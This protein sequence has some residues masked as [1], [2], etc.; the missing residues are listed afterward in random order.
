[1]N[2]K[3]K[4]VYNKSGEKVA[5][6]NKELLD[7]LCT[8]KQEKELTEDIEFKKVK[9]LDDEIKAL[10][11]SQTLSPRE[12]VKIISQKAKEF[13]KFL[14]R[15]RAAPPQLEAPAKKDV[16]ME[17]EETIRERE[18]AEMPFAGE[19]EIEQED[20]EDEQEEEIPPPAKVPRK[21]FPSIL[22]TNPGIL[23]RIARTIPKS[24]KRDRMEEM[25]E[26]IN[27]HPEYITEHPDSG[28]LVIN[29]REVHN[30]NLL[31]AVNLATY[32]VPKSKT[33]PEYFREF[34]AALGR[35]GIDPNLVPYDV[36]KITVKDPAGAMMEGRGWNGIWDKY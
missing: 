8:T 29:G 11:A 9:T 25:I 10:L 3:E 22:T 34:L 31:D 7:Y 21:I 24:D 1:M 6:V 35:S 5:L 27:Q 32:K 16:S 14:D 13:L 15:I 12:K 23:T 2:T 28:N 4:T 17:A 26:H 20:D 19:A 36:F 18:A 30:V 33:E